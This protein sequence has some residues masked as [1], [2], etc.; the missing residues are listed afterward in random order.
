MARMFSTNGR[1]KIST[2]KKEFKEKF[3]H[4]ELGVLD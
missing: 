3:P 1:K 4:L 2:L